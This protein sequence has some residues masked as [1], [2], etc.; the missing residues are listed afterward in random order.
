LVREVFGED[1]TRGLET[2]L[3]QIS[4]AEEAI[5]AAGIREPHLAPRFNEA[6][7]MLRWWCPV[8]VTPLIYHSHVEELLARV[9]RNEGL[10]PGTKAEVLTVL[11]QVGIERGLGGAMR[12][13]F[14]TLFEELSEQPFPE[15]KEPELGADADQLFKEISQHLARGRR[16]MDLA[17]A[18]Q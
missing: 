17:G 7:A 1:L 4:I 3:E 12:H 2:V 9:S 6:F 13:L 8:S 15:P 14:A 10:E 18:K 16:D 5:R 11:S